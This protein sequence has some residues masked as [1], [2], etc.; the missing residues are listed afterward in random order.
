MKIR[1]TLTTKL[2]CSLHGKGLAHQSTEDKKEKGKG[3]SRLLKRVKTHRRPPPLPPKPLTPPSPVTYR[4]AGPEAV[5]AGPGGGVRPLPASMR[6]LW[7]REERGP[8]SPPPLPPMVRPSPGDH[9]ARPLPPQPERGVQNGGA[10]RPLT[11][12]TTPPPATLGE[13]AGKSAAAAYK[14]SGRTT[15]RRGGSGL[16]HCC[17]GGAGGAEAAIFCSGL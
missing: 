10:Q 12:R 3:I 9:E 6:G 11:E 5:P 2:Y 7:G 13:R 4:G 1:R 14:G 16:G 8:F 15:L 17:R